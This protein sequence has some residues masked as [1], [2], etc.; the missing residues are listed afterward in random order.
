MTHISISDYRRHEQLAYWIN[1]YNAL[2]VQLIATHFPVNSIREIE[3]ENSGWGGGPWEAKLVV[4]EGIELSL[5]DIEHRI[6][7][8]IW[9]DPRIHY[10][11]NCASIG[12]PNLR[13]DAYESD[14]VN[15]V[16]D[17]AA[18][19]FINNRRGVMLENG[20]VI[21]SS[22]YVWFRP[23]FGAS[24]EAVLEHLRRY[25][26]PTLRDALKGRKTIADHRY[27]WRLNSAD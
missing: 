21:V 1:L 17:S 7:R 16:L 20:E 26:G 4:I 9:R 18:R 10:A 27:D 5:N 12:C 25:A 22:L 3:L 24:D 19:D 2:T 11:V 15:R 14:T 13:R 6:L 8:P 23:D